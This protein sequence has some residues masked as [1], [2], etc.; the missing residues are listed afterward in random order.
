MADQN[1]GVRLLAAEDEAE[2]SESVGSETGS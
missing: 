2:Q 1:V